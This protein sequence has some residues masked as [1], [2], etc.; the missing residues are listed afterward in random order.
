M[1]SIKHS[2]REGLL[3]WGMLTLAIS[4]LAA[5][6][7]QSSD[8]TSSGSVTE[9]VKALGARQMTAIAAKHPSEPG[10]YI[11]AM[12][13]PGVQ[14]LVISA[15]T[16]SPEYIEARLTAGAYA[17]V[18]AALQQGIPESK[19]FIH[20]MGGDG[21]RGG[22]HGRYR[23]R[24]RQGCTGDRRRSPSGKD[25]ESRIRKS[26]P[27]ARPEI[28]RTAPRPGPGSRRESIRSPG[29][30]LTRACRDRFAR[31]PA[32][33]MP[34]GRVP[35]SGGIVCRITSRARNRIHGR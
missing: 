29:F 18:Y 4:A 10:R 24:A 7:L 34:R 16:Q 19:L 32:A 9:L 14:L 25:V 35:P 31:Q 13:F 22:R 23:V 15:R 5:A 11:A 12:H 8:V 1:R 33:M 17:D 26:H 27:A 28:H 3:R 30:T 20:D 2:N 6:P 21:L